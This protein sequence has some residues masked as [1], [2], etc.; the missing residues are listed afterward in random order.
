MSVLKK[1]A[2]PLLVAILVL[3]AAVC[4]GHGPKPAASPPLLAIGSGFQGAA[5]LE[6]GQF[7]ALWDQ[8]DDVVQAHS[9]LR[10]SAYAEAARSEAPT[11][12]DAQLRKATFELSDYYE[13]LAAATA[14]GQTERDLALANPTT[15]TVGKI[16]QRRGP[17]C[18][19]C[20]R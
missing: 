4:D 8:F 2:P 18:V 17:R 5:R 14:R 16:C 3:V 7:T 6:C 9:V 20:E 12:E 1:L 10:F 13:H 15:E 19:S 11:F